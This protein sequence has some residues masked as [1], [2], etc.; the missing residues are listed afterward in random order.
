ML[1]FGYQRL[2]L[3][4]VLLFARDEFRKGGLC[5]HIGLCGL[6]LAGVEHDRQYQQKNGAEHEHDQ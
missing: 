2:D 1:G 3:V 5:F 6:G 4:T